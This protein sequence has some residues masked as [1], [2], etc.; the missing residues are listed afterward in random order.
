M[1]PFSATSLLHT[2]TP[3]LLASAEAAE[4]GGGQSGASLI[5][6]KLATLPMAGMFS[7]IAFAFLATL[8]VSKLSTRVGIPAIL[9]VLLLGV[10]VTPDAAILSPEGAETLH[11]VSLSMLLFYAGL[12]SNFTNLR[13]LLG[14]GLLLAVGGVMV[15]S[16]LFAAGIWVISHGTGSLVPGGV[17]LPLSVCFLVASCLGSTDAGATLSVLRS[18]R[19]LVPPHIKTLVEFESS[20]NDPAAIL[21]L[22]LVIGLSTQTA[23]QDVDSIHSIA[24]QIQT[25][26]K[27]IGS[28]IMVGLILTYVAQFILNSVLTSRDQV[29]VVGM[30]L[31][32]ASYGISTLL[33]GSGYITAFVTGAFLSNN[34]YK[35]PYITPEL[36]ENSLEPFNTMM[37]LV[38]FMLFGLLFDPSKLTSYI[39]PGVLMSLM[40]MFIARPLSVIV[41]KPFSSLNQRETALVCWCGLR[42]A[43]PLALSY[44]VIHSLPQISGI[45]AE[46]ARL[47][48]EEVQNLIFVIVVTNL[49]LQ[50]FSLPKVCRWLGFRELSDAQL[51]ASN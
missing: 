24:I 27:S 39:L 17:G 29:L 36:V 9:G 23:G 20:I 11:V 46:Q 32:M 1:I 40:L 16:V 5:Q 50:G 8:I 19:R 22:L 44:S 3:L 13:Q 26:L 45:T 30:S 33:G 51:A 28:G 7:L 41:F 35:N 31:A 43:V 49:C 47:I 12:S 2:L 25:F 21:F 34:I 14:Y 15:S 18:V 37:E 48:G 38:V 6:T 42:G 10:I 4:Q